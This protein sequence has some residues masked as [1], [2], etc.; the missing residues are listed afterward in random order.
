MV[1]MSKGIDAGEVVVACF[2][3]HPIDHTRCAGRGSDLA[4]IEHFQGEGIIGLVTSPVRHLCP[5][6]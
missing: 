5:G 4:W 1:Y 2:T 3:A 6:F